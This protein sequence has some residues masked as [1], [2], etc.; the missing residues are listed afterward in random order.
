MH[1]NQTNLWELMWALARTDFKLRFHGSL[2]GYLWALLKPLSLFLILNF[3][4]SSIFNPMNTGTRYYSLQ[5]ITSLM[6]FGFFQDG[7]MNGLTALVHKSTLVTKIYVP[8]WIII[9]ASTIHTTLVFA[10][11]LI[12]ISLFFLWYG[13]WPGLTGILA[14]A[15]YIVL[16]YGLILAFSFMAAPLFV[17][18]RDLVQV[19]E[20]VSAALFYATPIIYPLTIF[21]AH[22][23]SY[24]LVNPMAFIVHYTKMALTEQQFAGL[25]ENALFAAVVALLFGLGLF[26][27]GRLEPSVAE[28][29]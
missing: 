5:L 2:L 13:L 28:H 21:P 12:I 10:I 3:V 14:F 9:L 8:R 17:R 25:G 4:F 18:F 26:I 20:V 29:I 27:Y 11:N 1:P 6:L 16:T 19:W 23:Q 22:Y 7:T 15:F 24:V